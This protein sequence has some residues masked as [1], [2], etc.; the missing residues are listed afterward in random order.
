MPKKHDP[1]IPM[2]GSSSLVSVNTGTGKGVHTTAATAIH[3]DTPD[4]KETETEMW[5]DLNKDPWEVLKERLVQEHQ[6]SK[7]ATDQIIRSLRK[8]TRAQYSCYLLQFFTHIKK[9]MEKYTYVD[10]LEFLE[11]LYSK[12]KLGYSACNIARSAVSTFFDIYKGEA[13][14]KH[15]LIC[16]Y[17]KGLFETRPALPRYSTMWDPEILLEFLKQKSNDEN[18][19]DLS[20]KLVTLITLLSG[21]RVA[22][23]ANIKLDDIKIDNDIM[24]IYIS[25]LIK[26]TKPGKHQQPLQFKRYKTNENICVVKL[27]EKYMEKTNK[28]RQKKLMDCG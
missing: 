5:F 2:L 10:L 13:I 7:S 15:R 9:P 21:Q 3:K 6:I 11:L 27:M 18:L 26:Q 12:N 8:T 16:R 17:M 24:Y 4:G 23:I 19:L 28:I 25:N 1:S 14:G 22:T 20:K